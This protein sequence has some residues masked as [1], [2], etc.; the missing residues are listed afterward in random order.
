MTNIEL[1]KYDLL[2]GQ[3]FNQ[4]GAGLTDSGFFNSVQIL[5][6]A[7]NIKLDPTRIDFINYLV[8]FYILHVAEV[9]INSAF[10][11]VE[12]TK[13]AINKLM[14]GIDLVH[15]QFYSTPSDEADAFLAKYKGIKRGEA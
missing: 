9:P 11:D 2:M 8:T 14:E 13:H 3:L 5:L 7:N 1:K 6:L 4:V 15:K 12:E 10:E